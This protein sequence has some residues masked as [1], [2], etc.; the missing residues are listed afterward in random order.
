MGPL[1]IQNAPAAGKEILRGGEARF[2]P[3]SLLGRDVGARDP[4]QRSE[5]GLGEARGLAM[6]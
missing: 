4:R 5:V 6:V 3:V 1:N 2:A